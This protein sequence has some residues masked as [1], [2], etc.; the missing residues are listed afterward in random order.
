MKAASIT[1]CE[2]VHGRTHEH[3]RR[4]IKSMPLCCRTRRSVVLYKNST[5]SVG[6]NQTQSKPTPTAWTKGI[7][8]FN[9]FPSHTWIPVL[10]H[11]V[12]RYRS[13]TRADGTHSVVCVESVRESDSITT[14]D[15]VRLLFSL[16]CPLLTSIIKTCE[17]C[18][19]SG[20]YEIV[21]RDH[22]VVGILVLVRKDSNPKK[23]SFWCTEL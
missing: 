18:K 10:T 4:V 17:V 5:T 9:L 12:C 3:A 7:R 1:A 2:C 20:K 19:P 8:P 13:N 6:K 16:L 15:C 23:E 21:S 22:M 14:Y 11:L